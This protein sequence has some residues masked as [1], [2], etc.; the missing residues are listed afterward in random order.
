MRGFGEQARVVLSEEGNWELRPENC[1]ARA[2]AIRI[3]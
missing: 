2:F 1:R 3:E